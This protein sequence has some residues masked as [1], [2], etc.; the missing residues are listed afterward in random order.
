[1]GSFNVQH[2]VTK[3]WSIG[4]VFTLFLVIYL[5]KTWSKCTRYVKLEFRC[6]EIKLLLLR[7]K[8]QRSSKRRQNH[9]SQSQWESQLLLLRTECPFVKITRTN[10][11]TSFVCP[12][13]S[14]HVRCAKSSE[15]IKIAMWSQSKKPTTT[16]RMSFENIWL[17]LAL[18]LNRFRRSKRTLI[19]YVRVW[20]LH[21]NEPNKKSIKLFSNFAL[22][23]K[24]EKL[25]WLREFRYE[26]NLFCFIKFLRKM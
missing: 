21:L 11:S 14:R 25:Q 7:L 16:K 15:N 1:M 10:E 20:K 13:R 4:M 8:L 2:A 17:D 18:E 22:Y 23:L 9:Q 12:V 6:S 3:L 5:L 26:F 19:I 24:S